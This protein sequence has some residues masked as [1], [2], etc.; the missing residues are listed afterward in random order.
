MANVENNSEK[1]NQQSSQFAKDQ[2]LKSDVY[3]AIEE[4]LITSTESAFKTEGVKTRE[5]KDAKGEQGWN[6][7]VYGDGSVY[8]VG[9]AKGQATVTVNRAKG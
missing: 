8:G 2:K 9:V 5:T 4:Q 7:G 3:D 6:R 1:N